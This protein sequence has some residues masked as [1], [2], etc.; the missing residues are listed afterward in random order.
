MHSNRDER[1]GI[2]SFVVV[3]VLLA[4]LLVGGIYLVKRQGEAAQADSAAQETAQIKEN[5]E[6]AAKEAENTAKSETDEDTTANSGSTAATG[7]PKGG[8]GNTTGTGSSRVATTG[9]SDV[10]STGPEDTLAIVVVMAAGVAGF[11]YYTESRRT[12]VR[13]ALK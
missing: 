10:P 8:D 1:G 5:A 13:S 6:N 2:V 9:P 3:G 11:W 12:L 7:Q 4:G